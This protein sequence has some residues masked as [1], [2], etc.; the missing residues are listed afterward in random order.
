M[1]SDLANSPIKSARMPSSEMWNGTRKAV[2]YATPGS[3]NYIDSIKR[4]YA[5]KRKK[6]K[7]LRNLTKKKN[8]AAFQF[9]IQ[10]TT[11]PERCDRL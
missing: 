1:T 6:K 5:V 3:I 9:C 4:Y 11:C 7:I 2:W 10:S 8:V